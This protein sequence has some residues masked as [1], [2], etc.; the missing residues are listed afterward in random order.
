MVMVLLGR[1]TV[2]TGVDP[3]PLGV[4]AFGVSFSVVVRI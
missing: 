3:E 4:V 1:A 2:V